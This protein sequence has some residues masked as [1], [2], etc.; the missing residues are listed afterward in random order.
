MMLESQDHFW[1]QVAPDYEKEFIDPYRAEVLSPLRKILLR[2]AQQGAKAVGDLGCGIG[3]LLPLLREHFADVFAVD[4]AE[5]MLE[6]ARD[7]NPGV[8]FLHRNLLDLTPLHGRLDVAVSVNSLVMPDVGDQEKAL[9]EI[10][11]CLKP[12]GHFVGILPAI[13]SI[14]YL[15]MLLLDRALAKGM[16]LPQARKNVTQLNELEMYD[17]AF[18]QFRFQ[19]IEQHFWQPFEIRHRFAKAGFRRVKIA[20]V[21]LAWKQFAG[22][23]D[24]KHLPAPWDW[25]FWARRS[26]TL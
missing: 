1:S 9:R 25:F 19:G 12:G 20:K 3:P 17:W 6:R 22:W 13:D 11:A 18:G 2:F 21:R 7:A 14:H 8:E 10:A 26:R 23:R 24:L 5:G 4:F 16:P 15:T